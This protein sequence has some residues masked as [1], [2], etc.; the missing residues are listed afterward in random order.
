[1]GMMS[2]LASHALCVHKYASRDRTPSSEAWP[3]KVQLFHCPKHVPLAILTVPKCGTTSTINWVLQ[4]E[5]LEQVRSIYQTGKAFL[6]HA[7]PGEFSQAVKRQLEFVA[8]KGKIPEEKLLDKDFA[9][10]LM[11]RA[12]HRYKPG[13]EGYDPSVTVEREFLPP[14]HL[15]PLCCL[16]GRQRQHVVLARNPF[17]RLMSY[18]RF[19]W[20]NNAYWGSHKTSWSGFADYYQFVL[21]VRDSKPGLFANGLDWVQESHNFCKQADLS[22]V[23][24]TALHPWICRTT[25]YTL[26]AYDVFH[27]RPVS[28]M[29]KD[30]R[31]LAGPAV[32]EDVLV[33][34]LETLQEDILTL[35]DSLCRRLSFCEKLPPFPSVLPGKNI[36]DSAEGNTKEH[37]GFKEATMSWRNCSAPPWLELWEAPLTAMVPGKV[38]EPQEALKYLR[39]MQQQSMRPN[40]LAWTSLL[41]ACAANGTQEALALAKKSLREMRAARVQPN[42]YTF[43]AVEKMFGP[44]TATALLGSRLAEVQPRIKRRRSKPRRPMGRWSVLCGDVEIVRALLQGSFA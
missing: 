30:E 1:M 9:S 38:A 40:I 4:M 12:L 6:H 37:C 20:L 39:Q 32:M 41:G 18:F 13:L 21:R 8:S 10:L 33:L 28:D 23:P 34:H 35:E 25:Y 16:Y 14:A 15:C 11:Y 29:V 22:R 3:V 44:A 42:E 2:F 24:G 27:L 43:K 7:G 5:G 36:R 19:S 31:F 17:V 26:S